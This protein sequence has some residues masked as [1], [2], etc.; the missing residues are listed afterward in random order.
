[1]RFH[2]RLTDEQVGR[3]LGIAHAASDALQHL[4]LACGQRLECR[5]RC[6]PHRGTLDECVDQPPCDGRRQ[7]RVTGGDGPHGAGELVSTDVLEQETRRSRTQRFVDVLVEIERGHDQHTNGVTATEHAARCFEAV[8]P[9]HANVHQDDVGSLGV[10]D[11]QRLESVRRL[12][13]DIDVRLCG[14]NRL[15]S[16]AH[17]GLV[18]NHDDANHG[19]AP[20]G[21]RARRRNPPS[22]PG[23]ASTAPPSSRTRSRIPVNPMP[24]MPLPP[25]PSSSIVITSSLP[26]SSTATDAWRAEEWRMTLVRPSWITR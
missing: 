15:E 18:V 24:S 17:H 6:L 7:Q 5:R 21:I 12:A 23:P 22:G 11:L 2:G 14:E 9:R 20:S 8:E 10:H 26:P 19:R 13:H 4:T 16:G 3:D 25:T 1:M